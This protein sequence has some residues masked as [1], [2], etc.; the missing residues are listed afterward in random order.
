M[1]DAVVQD[2]STAG[3][4]LGAV[5]R[6]IGDIRSAID[7]ISRN[8]L[9]DLELSLWNQEMSC[10][11]L[12][13]LSRSSAA[14]AHHEPS[15]LRKELESLHALTR[16]YE[17]VVQRAGASTSLLLDLGSLHRAAAHDTPQSSISWEA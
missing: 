12:K 15:L 7:A 14:I 5:R 1:S 10:A 6:L 17:R 4:Y 2:P 9:S 11:S 13:R 3:I 16:T 8:A